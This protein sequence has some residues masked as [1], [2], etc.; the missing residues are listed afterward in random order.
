MA[1][2]SYPISIRLAFTK[3]GPWGLLG[4]LRVVKHPIRGTDASSISSAIP[5]DVA[6]SS[7][8]W[9]ARVAKAKTNS[10]LKPMFQCYFWVGTTPMELGRARRP[11]WLIPRRFHK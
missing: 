10:R 5:P 1:S 6:V 9:Q 7:I 3:S 2:E 11:G 4:F 8:P